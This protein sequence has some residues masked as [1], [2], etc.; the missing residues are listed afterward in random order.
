MLYRILKYLFHIHSNA[1]K[2][3]LFK[4]LK[5]ETSHNKVNRIQKT[6]G[7]YKHKSLKAIKLKL[8]W[9]FRK[10]PKRKTKNAKV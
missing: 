3:N 2:S 7:K 8:G 9:L 6:K 4:V 1:K 5:V 10:N